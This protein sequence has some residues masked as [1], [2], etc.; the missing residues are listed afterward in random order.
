MPKNTTQ[1]TQL[2]FKPRP[3]DPESNA[4]NMRPP[5]THEFL[6]DVYLIVMVASSRRS[7]SHGAVQKIAREKLKKS[8]ARGSERTPVGKLNKRSSWYTGI[9]SD[10]SI[11][12][13]FVNNRALL[14]QMRYTIWRRPETFQRVTRCSNLFKKTSWR[15]QWWLV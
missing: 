8:T 2:G 14:T 6:H 5:R 3:L 12:R 4:L 7:V 9:P 11:L 10:W 15:A 1:C 13:D